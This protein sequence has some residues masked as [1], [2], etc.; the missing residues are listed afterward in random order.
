M[1]NR[2]MEPNA[3]RQARLAASAALPLPAF[4]CT[5]WFGADSVSKP[6]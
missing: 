2:E 1:Y 5:L 3:G 4:A 6:R